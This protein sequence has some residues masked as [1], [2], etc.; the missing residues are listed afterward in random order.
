MHHGACSNLAPVYPGM[1]NRVD[2]DSESIVPSFAVISC[3]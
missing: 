3:M 2:A 1:K